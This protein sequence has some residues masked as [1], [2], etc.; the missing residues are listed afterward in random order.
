MTDLREIN[1]TS[2]DKN[3]ID[4]FSSNFL[5]RRELVIPKYQRDYNWGEKQWKELL[6]DLKTS[7]DEGIYKD[8]LGSIILHKNKEGDKYFVIDGQ[9]RIVTLL[10]LLCVINDSFDVSGFEYLYEE[11]EKLN[12]KWKEF[13]NQQNQLPNIFVFLKNYFKSQNIDSVFSEFI[14]RAMVTIIIVD[15][16]VESY[17]L[18]GRLNTRGLAL[19]SVDLIR[20]K[21]ISEARKKGKQESKKVLECWEK[22]QKN[23]AGTKISFDKFMLMSWKLEHGDFEIPKDD[24]YEKFEE[25]VAGNYEAITSFLEKN[26]NYSERLGQFLTLDNTDIEKERRRY[27]YEAEAHFK[28][29]VYILI[30]ALSSKN[31]IAR[32]DKERLAELISFYSLFRQIFYGEDNS[33]NKAIFEFSYKFFSYDVENENNKEQQKII[34]NLYQELLKELFKSFPS[35]EKFRDLITTCNYPGKGIE[36]NIL[37]FIIYSYA[38][39]LGSNQR[40]TTNGRFIYDFDDDLTIEHVIDKSDKDEQHLKVGNFLVL[41][42]V[43]NSSLS[44]EKDKNYLSKKPEYEKSIIVMVQNF[45]STYNKQFTN[46][47][48]VKRTDDIIEIFYT[49]YFYRFLDSLDMGAYIKEEGRVIGTFKYSNRSNLNEVINVPRLFSKNY[50]KKLQGEIIEKI[51]II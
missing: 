30:L 34:R 49:Y 11:N 5:E 41:E 46:R 51:S 7:C 28:D 6:E 1:I 19:N 18:F 45:N 47:N 42:K 4:L 23:L 44:K 38:R 26:I 50:D 25:E 32:V 13:I 3:I 29:E 35:P 2:V 39:Q 14:S 37:K 10:I 27:F 20:Y 31:D 16:E 21:I 22:I 24:I 43:I 12:P 9:Q 36:N 40:G 17:A 15:D 33:L 8:F 48:I